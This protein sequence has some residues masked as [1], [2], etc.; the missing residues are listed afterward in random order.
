MLEATGYFDF[1]PYVLGDAFENM[2]WDEVLFRSVQKKKRNATFRLYG[3][4]QDSISLGYF[5][6]T[7][8]LDR[9]QLKTKNIA[10]VRRMTGGRAVYHEK[11]LTYSL[12]LQLGKRTLSKKKLFEEMSSLILAG[13]ESLGWTCSLSGLGQKSFE[14]LSKSKSNCFSRTSF[15][16]IV[17][18]KGKKRVGMALLI[19]DS[20]LLAQGSIPL[21]EGYQKIE[22][23][24]KEDFMSS[25]SLLKENSEEDSKKEDSLNNSVD[26]QQFIESFLA[27]LRKKI[28]LKDT[29]L[30]QTEKTHLKQQKEKYQDPKW[31]FQR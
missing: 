11:E 28:I 1:F 16:E 31:T 2:A 3:W 20:S 22:Q 18:Q 27:G 6:G 14:P 17:D 7:Q 30:T 15:C 25:R 9:K 5:Q 10:L 12:S 8:N 23:F 21:N 29:S 4:R 19:Q 13:L 24:F 26:M